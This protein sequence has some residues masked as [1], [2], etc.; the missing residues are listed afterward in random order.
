MNANKRTVEVFA[1]PLCGFTYTILR[2]LFGEKKPGTFLRSTAVCAVVCASIDCVAAVAGYRTFTYPILKR[3]GIEPKPYRLWENNGQVGRDDCVL[4]GGI[5]GTLVAL[6]RR[7]F[8]SVVGWRRYVGAASCGSTAGLLFGYL[9]FPVETEVWKLY[10]QKDHDATGMKMQLI[11]DRQTARQLAKDKPSMMDWIGAFLR[12]WMPEFTSR[13]TETIDQRTGSGAKRLGFQ[14]EVEDH[15]R[16]LPLGTSPHPGY[17]TEGQ[18][19]FLPRADYDWEPESVDEGIKV[20]KQHIE[21]LQQKR[22]AL[23]KEAEYTW[24]DLAKKEHIFYYE[25]DV[26]TKDMMKRELELLS[27]IHYRHWQEISDI[28]WMIADSQKNIRQSELFP[29]EAAVWLPQLRALSNPTQH[30]PQA[31]L[32][33]VREHWENLKMIIAKTEEVLLV[34]NIPQDTREALKAEQEGMR[35]NL[36]ATELLLKEYEDKVK[37]AEKNG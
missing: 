8:Q 21:D 10:L 25:K 31:T 12:S 30:S 20:L 29:S 33:H 2:R 36:K 5:L 3:D 24:L 26:E 9:R 22:A 17:I 16:A 4:A 32:K 13:E 14:I 35:K 23:A 34:A 27:G 7:P 18:T 1:G 28:N 11:Q 37:E 6:R 19:K 15:V